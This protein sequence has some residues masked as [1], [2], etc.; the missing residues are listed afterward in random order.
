M[1]IPLETMFCI[2]PLELSLWRSALASNCRMV[3]LVLESLTTTD[4]LGNINCLSSCSI[5]SE[6]R[7]WFPNLMRTKLIFVAKETSSTLD[8]I[9]LQH[10]WKFE[11]IPLRRLD[12]FVDYHCKGLISAFP[13]CHLIILNLPGSCCSAHSFLRML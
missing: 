11:L 1:I 10:Y 7:P 9:F 4:I 5:Q 8:T 3:H 13:D 2:L 12:V 6:F